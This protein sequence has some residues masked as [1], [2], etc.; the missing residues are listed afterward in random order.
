MRRAGDTIIR[1]WGRWCEAQ[2]L[3]QGPHTH[4]ST[5]TGAP[6]P[7][8]NWSG[9]NANHSLPS[10]TK[11]RNECSYDSILSIC[12]QG[13]YWDFTFNSIF[14][15]DY[16]HLSGSDK[17]LSVYVQDRN[18]VTNDS[19]TW[20]TKRGCISLMLCCNM[21]P[22]TEGDIIVQNVFY[23]TF[24]KLLLFC[25]AACHFCWRFVV[26]SIGG[27]MSVNINIILCWF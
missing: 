25:G 21:E 14:F 2:I 10:S 1:L 4:Y 11:A 3:L 26:R 16:Y 7:G 27:I 19:C 20:V 18:I 6:S 17:C 13:E 23:S 9:H 22:L 12:F 8:I 15:C 5:G 24:F